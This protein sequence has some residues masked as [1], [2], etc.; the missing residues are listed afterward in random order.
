MLCL[1]W[2]VG[3]GDYTVTK[4]SLGGAHIHGANGAV[5]NVVDSEAVACREIARFLSYLPSNTWQLPPRQENTDPPTR[6][7]ESL[8]TAVARDRRQPFDMRRII[9]SVVDRDSFFEVFR[10]LLWHQGIVA[11]AL[12]MHK[13]QES[14]AARQIGAGWGQSQIVGFARLDGHVVGVLANEP[15][16]DGGT[17]TGLSAQ[18]V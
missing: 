10:R 9:A 18:K 4:E 5:D 3:T 15:K 8:L 16:V 14:V 12:T 1:N 2:L 7:D 11:T 6:R 17:M 13:G